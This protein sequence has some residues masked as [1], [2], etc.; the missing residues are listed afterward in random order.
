MLSPS[1]PCGRLNRPC[2]RAHAPR[3]WAGPARSTTTGCAVFRWRRTRHALGF[4][5]RDRKHAEQATPAA[6]RLEL[7]RDRQ[8][9][10]TL[11]LREIRGMSEDAASR[12]AK[13]RAQAA[14][15]DIPD[16]CK[17]ASLNKRE[18]TLLAEAG[19]LK[20]LAGHRNDVR[21]QVAQS[22]GKVMSR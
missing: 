18:Q 21:W 19:A 15:R 20:T 16:L 11:G 7:D 22:L 9:E 5:L 2:V 14:F 4:V 17:R 10:E 12:I 13:A 3:C 6:L 8:V 1:T